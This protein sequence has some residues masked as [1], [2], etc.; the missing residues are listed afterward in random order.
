MYD[1]NYVLRNNI[2][3]IIKLLGIINTK[4]N[5]M[6]KRLTTILTTL[7]VLLYIADNITR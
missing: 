7:F 4:S 2:T 5:L 6:V 3:F 1:V